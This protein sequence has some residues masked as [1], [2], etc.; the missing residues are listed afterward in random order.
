MKHKNSCL[1][2]Q[3]LNCKKS[4]QKSRHFKAYSRCDYCN[5]RDCVDDYYLFYDI[6]LRPRW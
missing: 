1:Q 2:I 3:N 5:K 6:L 4:F